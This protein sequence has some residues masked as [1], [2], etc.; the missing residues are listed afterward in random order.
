MRA[1]DEKIPI[2]VSHDAGSAEVLSAYLLHKGTVSPIC[3][4]SGPATGIF[5]EKLGNMNL[6]SNLDCLKNYDSEGYEVITGSSWSSLIE[7][8]A[9]EMAKSLDLKVTT[10][11]DHWTFYI[12][13]FR[14]ND[15]QVFPDEIWVCDEKARLMCLQEFP[16]IPVTKVTNYYRESIIKEVACYPFENSTLNNILVVWQPFVE[17]N[18]VNESFNKT[19]AKSDSQILDDLLNEVE[20]MIARKQSEETF[21]VRIRLHPSESSSKYDSLF[22]VRHINGRKISKS[23]ETL[24]QDISWADTVVGVTTM[25]LVL[26]FE[27]GKE[28]LQFLPDGLTVNS[29]DHMNFQRLDGRDI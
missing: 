24:A 23:S 7:K 9:I 27:C 20:R 25:A 11:I 4:L 1:M 6:L 26:A 14:L 2:V 22:S 21:S 13:R 12:S 29:L 3:L 8:H 28:V 18:K 10:L 19:L 15:R 16:D 17:P 5:K